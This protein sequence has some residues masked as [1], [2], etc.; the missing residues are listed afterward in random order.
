MNRLN[1]RMI[2]QAVPACI[3]LTRKTGLKLHF[4]QM[5]SGPKP[6]FGV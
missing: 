1:G 2:G 3:D 4:L 6:R 5:G